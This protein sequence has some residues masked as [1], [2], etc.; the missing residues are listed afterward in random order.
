MQK[1]H[2]WS[3][4]FVENRDGRSAGANFSLHEAR[5]ERSRE[6]LRRLHHLAQTLVV[7]LVRRS[8]RRPAAKNRAHRD[9]VVL[10][11]HIL[12]DGVVGKSRERRT[13]PIEEA[14]D[15]IRTRVLLYA[16]ED[17][18]GLIVSQHKKKLLAF[19]S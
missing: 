5:K 1:E 14:L 10:L 19:S 12:M 4:A 15:L 17:V 3:V 16:G 18:S 7:K 8:T 9:A 13:A 11:R 6:I 2:W